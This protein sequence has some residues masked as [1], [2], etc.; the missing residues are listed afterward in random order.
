LDACWKCWRH[1]IARG[2]C[3]IGQFDSILGDRCTRDAIALSPEVLLNVMSMLPAALQESQALRQQLAFKYMAH[4]WPTMIDGA[5][6][7]S[8]PR[9]KVIQ[10]DVD[11]DPQQKAASSTQEQSEER[12]QDIRKWP[13]LIPGQ[14]CL[15]V[16]CVAAEGDRCVRANAPFPKRPFVARI[17]QQAKSA[18]EGDSPSSGEG[19]GSGSAV[20]RVPKGVVDYPSKLASEIVYCTESYYEVIIEQPHPM[21]RGRPSAADPTIAIGLAT[22]DFSLTGKQPGWDSRGQSYGYHG[23]DGQKYY[24]RG[25]GVEFGPEYGSGDT[26]GCGVA[27]LPA[28]VQIP[29]R[30][31]AL[32]PLKVQHYHNITTTFTTTL[33]QH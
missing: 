18:S 5:E 28:G 17:V 30:G 27:Y 8:H 32:A 1:V 31:R 29:G 6:L 22:K 13:M 15:R 24:T 3:D 2:N 16:L 19:A 10:L 21:L 26:V 7:P 20:L 33:T 12:S 4:S 25:R 14:P 9:D 23:D 11:E